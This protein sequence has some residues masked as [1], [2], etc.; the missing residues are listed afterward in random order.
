[1]EGKG[2]EVNTPP[3]PKGGDI[4][5]PAEL[6]EWEGMQDAWE[7]FKEVRK[8]KRAPLTVKA[9]NMIADKLAEWGPEKALASILNSVERGYTGVFIP[10]GFTVTAPTPP[11][12]TP[13][14]DKREADEAYHEFRK[15]AGLE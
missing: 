11:P 15:L 7:A 12:N 13:E 1:L 3:T 5:L 10:N 4:E 8:K 9:V 2:K 14:Q 6:L